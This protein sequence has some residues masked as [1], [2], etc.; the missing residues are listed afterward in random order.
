MHEPENALA[1]ASLEYKTS[2]DSVGGVVGK[3]ARFPWIQRSEAV[4]IHSPKMLP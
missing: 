1:R 2:L 3:D 4:D